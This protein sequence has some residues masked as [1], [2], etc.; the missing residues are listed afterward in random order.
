LHV[1]I[2]ESGSFSGYHSAS[3]S[4]VGALADGK[5]ELIQ[6]K[7]AKIR[8]HLPTEKGEAKGRLLNER[9]VDKVVTLLA[10]NEVIFEMSAID[11][12]FQR[13]NDVAAYRRRDVE[14]ILS[15]VHRFRELDRQQVEKISRQ[16]LTV[17]LPLYVQ[18]IVTFETLHSVIN[19]IPLYF[20]QRRPEELVKFSW[21]ID[22][23]DAKKVTS[24]LCPRSRMKT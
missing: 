7:Y 13:E 21:I 9:Q 15:R 1:F 24:L 16:I 18:A 14:E 6:R 12:G 20:S 5:I 2:D 3:V 8:G 10:R 11:L 17:S 19:H 4:V 23:K 22:G